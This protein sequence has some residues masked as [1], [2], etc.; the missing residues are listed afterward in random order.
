M[1]GQDEQRYDL[2]VSYAQADRA[3]VEGYLTTGECD[4]FLPGQEYRKTCEGW[5]LEGKP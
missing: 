1:A 3:W 4:T 5:P 2:F